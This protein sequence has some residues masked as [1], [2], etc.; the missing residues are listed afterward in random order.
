MMERKMRAAQWYS[1]RHPKSI[2]KCGH[3]GDG[4]NSEH[5]GLFAKGHGRCLAAGCDC[6]KFTWAASTEAF[7]QFMAQVE[8]G[9]EPG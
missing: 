4:G 8:A 1:E 6:E 3:A 9:A 2:C 7:T 5:A